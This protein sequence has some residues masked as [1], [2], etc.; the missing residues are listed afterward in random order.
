MKKTKNK[1]CTKCKV[2][3]KYSE[4]SICRNKK[5]GI[6]SICKHCAILYYKNKKNEKP[7]INS[8]TS[9][10]QRCTNPL[11]K[12]YINYDKFDN[13]EIKFLLSHKDMNYLWNRDKGWILN[14]PSLKRI[15]LNNNYNIDNCQFVEMFK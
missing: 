4:F 2:N 10:K 1:I 8:Y 7:W 13:E 3:K 9:A 6:N 12:D 15:N 5:S 11:C 14:K